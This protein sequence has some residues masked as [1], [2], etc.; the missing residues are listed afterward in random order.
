MSIR[1]FIKNVVRILVPVF[2]F[3]IP[4]LGLELDFKL[5]GGYAFLDVKSIN[6]GLEDWTDWRK[7]EAEENKN[8]LYLGQNVQSLHSGIHLEGEILLSFS[9]RSL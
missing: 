1:N 8:W 5:S 9:F 6:R 2:L 7:R 3:G 4:V